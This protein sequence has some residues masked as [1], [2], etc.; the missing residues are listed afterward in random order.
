MRSSK[1]NEA[2]LFICI[3][4]RLSFG[5]TRLERRTSFDELLNHRSDNLSHSD[6]Y[7]ISVNTCTDRGKINK[8]DVYN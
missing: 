5:A 1:I 4:A 7:L 8:H 2:R 6:G 3:E